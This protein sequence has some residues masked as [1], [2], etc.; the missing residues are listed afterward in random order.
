MKMLVYA[1]SFYLNPSHCAR[2][3]MSRH[4]ASMKSTNICKGKLATASLERKEGEPSQRAPFLGFSLL[5]TVSQG[6]ASTTKL[7]TTSKKG[8]ESEASQRAPSFTSPSHATARP[9]QAHRERGKR[10]EVREPK[11][12]SNMAF[13]R[14][15]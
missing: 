6:E 15:V 1:L 14:R 13:P 10:A 12:H 11:I 4:L 7:A 5:A 2:K 8:E 3:C 9:W